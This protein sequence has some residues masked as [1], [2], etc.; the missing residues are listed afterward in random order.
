M[1]LHARVTPLSPFV[2]Y[3]VRAPGEE[4]GIELEPLRPELIPTPVDQNRCAQLRSPME[5]IL[6]GWSMRRFQ[7]WQQ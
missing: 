5:R 4:D 3:E 7:A 6:Q 2:Q 1:R